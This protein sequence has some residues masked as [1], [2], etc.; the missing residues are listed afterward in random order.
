MKPEHL[1]FC[2]R[3]GIAA[4]IFVITP[5]A[6]ADARAETKMPAVGDQAPDFTL[7]TLDD[8]PV[9]LS[10]LTMKAPVVLVVLRGYPGYQCP[11]CTAQVGMLIGKAKQLAATG[12]KV[13]LVYPGPREQLVDQGRAFLKDKTL[14]ENFL[15][16]TDPDYKFTTSY[17]LR[18][19]AP[20]ETAFPSTFVLDRQRVV[21]FAKVSKS[22]GDRAKVAEILQA[23]DAVPN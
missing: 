17:G 5:A 19:N 6:G 22:H 1:H 21:R 12:A 14:P 2:A 16:V 18:W 13:L 3:Y 11:I 9:M 23:L 20:R 8:R 15:F 10:Q 7:S 4:A